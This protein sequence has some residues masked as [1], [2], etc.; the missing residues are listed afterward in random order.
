MATPPTTQ[1]GNHNLT[2][3]YSVAPIHHLVNTPFKII[4]GAGLDK[5]GIGM[6][7]YRE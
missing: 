2:H 7:G 3:K 1:L 5:C 6:V 4:F